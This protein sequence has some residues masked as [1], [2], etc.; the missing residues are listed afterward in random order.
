[1]QAINPTM[2]SSRRRAWATLFLLFAVNLVNFYDRQVLGAVAEPLKRDWAL[3]DEQIGWLGTAFTLLYAV[4]GVPLGRWADTGRRTW[5]LARG[6]GLWS[7]LTAASGLAWSFWSL[8]VIRLGVGVGEATCAPAAN[9]LLGD[10]FPSERRARA[11]SIFMMGLPVGLALSF[12]VSGHIAQSW[13]WRQ[14]LVVAGLPGVMLGLLLLWTPEP[15]RGAS[16]KPGSG[17]THFH[18]SAILAVLRIPTVWW[19]IVSGALHNFNAYALSTF[20]SPLLQR[21]HGLSA[22][23][24]GEIN[25]LTYGCGGLGIL[26]GGWACDRRAKDRISGRLEVACGA[27]LVFVP[28]LLLALGRPAGDYWGFA[29][30]FL[31]GCMLTYVYYA[32][33]YAT[34]LDIVEPALRGTAMAIY[35]FAMYLLGASLGPVVMGRLSDYL[36]RRAAL[37]QGSSIVTD[38]DKAIGLHDSMY[39][40]P[41]LAVLLV[42]VLFVASRSVTRDYE[43]F[44]K[45]METMAWS[46]GKPGEQVVAANGPER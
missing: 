5:I 39:L 11:I 3:S 32:G 28:C 45:R 35:F 1:M 36:A 33:V 14:A 4:V 13:G 31:P 19:I 15:I 9:S 8:F 43:N 16:E 34:L 17:T 42:V 30:C 21:Y 41:V 12:L 26:F 37:A 10:L 38:A 23:Q 44:Q 18:G 27:L 6:V 25:A 2:D 7:L 20:L 40:V 24:A 29:L 22:S 46:N